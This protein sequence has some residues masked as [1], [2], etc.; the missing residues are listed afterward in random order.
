MTPSMPCHLD[1]TVAGGRRRP[2]PSD[3]GGAGR[4][5]EEPLAFDAQACTR[6][7][8]A[9]RVPAGIAVPAADHAECSRGHG[10]A[11]RE[12]PDRGDGQQV[13]LRAGPVCR[14]WIVERPRISSQGGPGWRLAEGRAAAQD[15][16]AAILRGGGC[17][18]SPRGAAAAAYCSITHAVARIRGVLRKRI[19]ART[20][21]RVLVLQECDHCIPRIL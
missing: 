12:L 7:P 18:S 5:P 1:K 13:P 6:Q 9:D 11:V 15:G 8:I 21:A 4:R 10:R 2:R 3:A 16:G 20:P 19:L 14:G 17:L